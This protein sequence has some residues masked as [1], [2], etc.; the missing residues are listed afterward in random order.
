MASL[1]WRA[2]RESLDRPYRVTL[3]MVALVSLVPVYLVIAEYQHG[4][5]PHAPA[6]P[7]DRLLPLA[8]AWAFVYG[9]LYLFLIVLPVFVVRQ[10]EHL[11][12]T[13][14]TYL[15]V[16]LA[17]YACFLVYPTVAPRPDR[18]AGSGFAAWGLGFLYGADPPY[19]C[20]PSLHVAHSFVS[21]LACRRV[22]RGVGA[23]ALVCAVL[24]AMSTLLTKQHY[25]VDVLAGIGLAGA[26]DHVFGRALLRV[27]IP[28]TE[29]RLAPV[30]ALASAAMVLVV[31][32]GFWAAYWLGM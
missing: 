21:A 5:V 29:R 32:V 20:F 30:F 22:H 24:V 31:F 2:A 6:L 8:P 12:R 19:N 1:P 26:A 13:V 17:A 15:C 3:S 23:V 14:A 18:V 27:P 9:A 28:A 10:E 4:R 16:W 11:R 25:V 7:L